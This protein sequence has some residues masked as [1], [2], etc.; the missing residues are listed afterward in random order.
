MNPRT[1]LSSGNGLA[2]A[3]VPTA[4]L[5]GQRTHKLKSQP[6]P[7]AELPPSGSADG[8]VLDSGLE[9]LIKFFS[10]LKLTVVCLTLGMILVFW[11]TLAQVELTRSNAQV[12]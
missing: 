8:S 11:G 1:R 10:S 2:A 4:A 7:K 9:A 3:S 12:F 5:P 6:A